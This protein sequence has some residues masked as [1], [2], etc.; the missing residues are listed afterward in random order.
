M[1]QN[2]FIISSWATNGRV[3]QCFAN[4]SPFS[5]SIVNQGTGSLQTGDELFSKGVQSIDT[6]VNKC[7]LD[8][9]AVSYLNNSHNYILR[10]RYAVER[11]T[12]VL[13]SKHLHMK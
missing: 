3:A 12:I 7:A 9:Q 11:I 1:L 8:Y 4:Q 13:H 2:V 5:L 10:Y 6:L